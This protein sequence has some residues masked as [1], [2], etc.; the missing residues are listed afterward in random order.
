MI[1]I[2]KEILLDS[3]FIKKN[4]EFELSLSNLCTKEHE[5][6][7]SNLKTAS[8][9]LN[10]KSDDTITANISI[11][12]TLNAPLYNIKLKICDDELLY[13]IPSSLRNISTKEF[14]ISKNSNCNSFLLG[15][16]KPYET[17]NLKFNIL[18]KIKNLSSTLNKSI[19]RLNFMNNYL[20][21]TP[22]RI[23]QPSLKITTLPRE[24]KIEIEN[25]GSSPLKNIV[26]RYEIPNGFY[27][28]TKSIRYDIKNILCTITFKMINNNLLFK[29]DNIPENTLKNRKITI[30]LKH[31]DINSLLSKPLMSVK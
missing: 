10:L 28:D 14:Y 23:D 31:I 3:S 20:N 5:E 19:N 24:N 8:E 21:N 30:Y 13:L 6:K 29:I 15:S 7:V 16:L 1:N 26:Y 9:Y 27:I 2:K 25:L 17:L 12:N 11:K 4:N 18:L 22:I